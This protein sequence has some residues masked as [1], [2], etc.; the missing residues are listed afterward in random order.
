MAELTNKHFDVIVIGG[1]IKGS[2][3]ARDAVGRGLKV[4]L[5]EQDD[6]GSSCI[7]ALAKLGLTG[8]R[9]SNDFDKTE[10]GKAGAECEIMRRVTPHL[11]RPS[12]EAACGV[13]AGR[14]AL[15]GRIRRRF[16]RAQHPARNIQPAFNDHR[17]VMLC[18]RDA[19]DRGACVLPR[20]KILSAARIDGNWSVEIRMAGDSKTNTLTSKILVDTAGTL[21]T[22]SET[23]QMVAGFGNRRDWFCAAVAIVEDNQADQKDVYDE[24]SS[25]EKFFSIPFDKGFRLLGLIAPRGLTRWRGGNP[26]ALDAL[27]TSN[28]N[29]AGINQQDRDVLWF[30]RTEF[31]TPTGATSMSGA[32]FGDYAIEIKTDG[33]SLPVLRVNGGS[34]PVARKLAEEVVAEMTDYANM[35]GKRWTRTTPLPGG[36][37]QI[38]IRDALLQK[39]QSDFPFLDAKQSVRLFESYGTDAARILAEVSSE[40]N[41]GRDFGAGLFEPEVR[42]LLNKEWAKTAEDI[43]WRRTL[44]GLQMVPS[45]IVALQNWIDTR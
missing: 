38:D 15:W 29:L 1:G 39:L 36:D 2:A 20:T 30:G 25:G 10:A 40:K 41:L 26:D 3:I 4:L 28:S 19:A 6:L 42:W 8:F 37:F 43:I 32:K 27:M 34:V 24:Q 11:W 35:I 9:K 7:K 16:P 22:S 18:A 45:Q 13:Y 21:D 5:C 44:L 14:S 17:Y 12:D 31:T 33:G 23:Q